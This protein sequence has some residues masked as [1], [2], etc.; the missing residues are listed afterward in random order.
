MIFSLAVII[1]AAAFVQKKRGGLILILLAIGMMLF[2]G[3]FG[4]PI[5]A[6]LAG[7]GGTGINAPYPRWRKIYKGKARRFFARLWPWVFAL[8][9]I[10]GVFLVIGSYVIAHV[11]DV[12]TSNIFVASFFLSIILLTATNIIGVAYDIEKRELIT[13]SE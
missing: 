11:V 2:G 8:C 13:G 3:G 5:M 6:I 10:D 7:A 4:P 12:D 9:L 1:W